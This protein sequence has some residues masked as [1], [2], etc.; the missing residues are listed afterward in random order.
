MQFGRNS[1]QVMAGC[2]LAAAIFGDSLR[3]GAA[4]VE[5]AE[6]SVALDLKNPG[7]VIP[8]GYVGLSF[9]VTRLL[10][11]SKGIY[12]FRPDNQS[13]IN[14]FHTLGIKN[15]RV[16]GNTSD[17]DARQL[18]GPADWDSFFA[19]AHAAQVKVIYGLQ[20]HKGDPAVAAQTVKYIMDRYAPLMD[21]FA[22][23][24]E[25]SA[26]PVTTTDSRPDHDKMGM[27][28]EHYTYKNYAQEWKRFAETITAAVPEAKFCGPGVH[29]NAQWNRQ[30]IADFGQSS[31][32]ALITTHLYAGG[33]GDKVP[34]P[35]VGRAQMLSDRF[36]ETYQKLYDGFVPM[37]VSN[38][39]PYRLEE[40][41]SFYNA[42]AAG[43]SDTFASALWGLD[44]LYWW[45]EHGAAGLNIHT[46]DRVAAGS[47][48]RPANYAVFLSCTNGYKTC[49]L[50]YGLKAFNLGA[51]GK[52]IP[53]TISNPQQVN[54][55]AYA[56]LDK[57]GIVYLTIVNKANGAAAKNLD[58]NIQSGTADFKAGKV[59][60][61]TAPGQDISTKTDQTLGGA[62]ISS[63]GDF[64]CNWMS[65][66]PSIR[67]KAANT[68]RVV[69]PAASAAVIKLTPERSMQ[70]SA[71]VS[72]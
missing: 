20:L 14:L 24:Q 64:T 16:G 30:F 32:V 45:A 21:A 13:L 3:A 9:E 52:M 38:G 40:A 43:V 17:R 18:P 33:A 37:A 15:L 71:N 10:P 29:N 36:T 22:I 41:N 60:F 65:L 58:L 51:H 69:I 50:G 11:D 55:S 8:P 53:L 48:L 68:F 5:E 34:D 42:G 57:N 49:P 19:F 27:G 28:A 59:I 23:G 54:M 66:E 61:L 39:L 56:T 12:F 62:E 2:L 70:A 31:H 4:T 46:G 6:V 1:V 26:Y 35:E 63:G 47:S 25:P 44:F 67:I 7:P 72:R